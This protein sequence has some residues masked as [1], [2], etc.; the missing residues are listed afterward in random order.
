MSKAALPHVDTWI[1]DL[2]MTLYPP[3][4]EIMALIEGKMTAY[5]ARHTGLSRD[6]A[7]ALQKGYL[8][9]HGTTLAGLMANHSIDPYDFLNEVHDVSLETLHP[10]AE[11]NALIA[12]LE[13]RKLVFTNGDEPHAVRIL[14]KLGMTGLFDG[15]FHLG[16]ADLIPKPNLSTY[17]RFVTAHGVT[18]TSSAF[19]E[20]SPKNL[21]PAKALGMTTILVGPKIVDNTDDFIDHRSPSVK[22]FLL[23]AAPGTIYTPA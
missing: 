7:Y 10:D 3:E 15:L 11:L 23:S 18:A 1:F 22:A 5:V 6:E 19:F 12:G 9:E 16:H 20:D 8:Y 4:A 14:K 13:G 21:K 17:Q 2:D